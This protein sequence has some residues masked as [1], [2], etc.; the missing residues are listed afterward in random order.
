[1][2]NSVQEGARELI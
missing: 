1:M 2:Q